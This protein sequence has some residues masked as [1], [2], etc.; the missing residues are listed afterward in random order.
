[1]NGINKENLPVVYRHNSTAW[2]TEEI[3]TEWLLSINNHYKHE[4]R[5]ILLFLDNKES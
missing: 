5:H 4:S 1:M 2:M 3:F